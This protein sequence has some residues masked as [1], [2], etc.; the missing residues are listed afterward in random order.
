MKCLTIKRTY[1]LNYI[2]RSVKCLKTYKKNLYLLPFNKN[3]I[4]DFALNLGNFRQLFG[5]I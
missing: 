1:T 3:K 4:V 5:C 2:S